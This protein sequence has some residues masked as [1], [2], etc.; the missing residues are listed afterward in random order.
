MLLAGILGMG[1]GLVI[2]FRTDTVHGKGLIFL[3]KGIQKL[4]SLGHGL[5]ERVQ[6]LV[7]CG[8]GIQ[9]QVQVIDNKTYLINLLKQLA[10]VRHFFHLLL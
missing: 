4:F 10:A 1:F 8:V 7:V 2:G 5:A 3:G 6:C 9:I